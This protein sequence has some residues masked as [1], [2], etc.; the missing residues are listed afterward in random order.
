MKVAYIVNQYPKV[1]HTFIRRE[2]AALEAAG[3]SVVRYSMR[4]A[5][6]RLVDAADVAEAQRTT[7]LLDAGVTG[8][9]GALL[10]AAMQR[11]A[12]FVRAL[13]LALRIGRRS[14]RGLLVNL[15]YLAEA[16]VLLRR[17]RVEGVRHVHAHFGANSA[18]VAMLANALGGPTYS[19][20]V[21]GPEE[22]DK[23]PVI[24]LREKLA[25]A[26]FVIAISHYGRS[27]LL[28]LLPHER[29]ARVHVV[30]CGVDDGFLGAPVA[31]VTAAPRLVCVGRLSEQKGQLLLV[32]AVAALHRRGR[33]V[34]LVLVGDGEMRADVEAAIA[35]EGLGDR[36][37]IT[38]W[39]DGEA[40][41]R[42]LGEARALV[43]PSFAE[44]LP[45]VIMEALALGRPVVSTYVAGIPELVRPGRNGWLVPAGSVE[46]LVEAVDE[47][48]AATPGRL[49]ELGRAGRDDV[50][51][52]HDVRAIG[53]QL[54]ALFEGWA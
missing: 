36:V 29:W 26:A 19:F 39:A 3:V 42:H 49:T 4:R 28:R 21:H 11:P 12:P 34:R 1:S 30:R 16:C 8:L 20:T 51:A 25:R 32:E 24:A 17:L 44:G 54:R 6:D 33:D 46:A 40:V 23:A 47:V 9:L 52:A 14:E 13:A 27:Q 35:R 2:I 5:A 53:G 15:I 18:A 7:V 22:F 48:L 10:S 31:D 45:V 38:G 37:Q 50:R 41:R 43:L